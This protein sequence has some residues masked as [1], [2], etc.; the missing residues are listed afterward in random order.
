VLLQLARP[1]EAL[2]AAD[3]VLALAPDDVDALILRGDAWR[4]LNDPQGAL[5]SFDR[6]L[7]VAPD[8]AEAWLGRGNVLSELARYDDAAPAFD[9]ALALKP[10]LAEAWL[11]RGNVL[12]E[13]KR[14]EEASA[15]YDKAATLKPALNY[16]AGARLFAKLL[17]C[18][19]TALDAQVAELLSAIRER[20]TIALPFPILA[21]PSSAADQLQCAANYVRHQP[22]FAP[23]WR[24][25]VFSHDR[26]RL[27][28][29]SADFHDSATAALLAGLFQRH[30]RSRFETTAISF[31]PDR[32]SPMRR[33][34]RGAFEHFI[35]VRNDSEQG[36][37]ELMRRLEVDIAVDLMGFT[38][39]NRLNVL[40]RRPAPIQVNYLGYPGT[41]GAGYIDYILADATVIP[42]DQCG[43]YAEQVVWLPDTYFVNDNTLA[44]SE[45]TP[46]RRDCGLPEAGFVF[47]CFNN[48]YKIMPEIFDVWMKL[49]S[50]TA[51][52]VLWLVEADAATS[53]NLRREAQ[54]RGVAP[55]RLI[56][57]PRVSLADHLARQRLADLFL[58][59]LPYNAHTMASDALWVG[60]PVLTCLGTTFAGRVAASLLKAIGLDELIA[61]SLPEYQALALE[62]A[63]DPAR[64]ASLKGRLARNRDSCALF[65]T[66]RATRAFE[67][68]Y[69]MMWE[70]QRSGEARPVGGGPI[71]V[72]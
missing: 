7:A 61:G 13:F 24:G 57:A 58:D 59:T 72:G 56:F 10:G 37:A 48:T 27:A 2:A 39:H 4:G 71:R 62:L 28:Y 64:L 14:H 44:V 33:R 8:R 60:L 15:A 20:S 67:A 42:E 16:A 5:A 26:I 68:A 23:L 36:I 21:V 70:R 1:D 43:F 52:S 55:A 51:D 9:R 66:A 25:E 3:R 32:D 17:L 69:R 47:C 63:H 50:A 18:D 38:K 49:L 41:M 29:L 34:L 53:A 11:G 35:D 22:T 30:D 40:A 46:S 19:W 65:D 45:R 6:A 31:G 12:T 54:S